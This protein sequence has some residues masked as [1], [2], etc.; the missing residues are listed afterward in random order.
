MPAKKV[1]AL[2][3]AQGVYDFDALIIEPRRARVGGELVDVSVI[4]VA[5]V[6]RLSAYADRFDTIEDLNAAAEEDPQGELRQLWQM[7]SDV[8]IVNNP[9][10][11]V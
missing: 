5:V 11:T 10:F 4:P 1:R 7:V 2:K 6:L 9:K 3:D 8:C